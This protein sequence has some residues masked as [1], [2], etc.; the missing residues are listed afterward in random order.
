MKSSPASITAGD[1]F[2]AAHRAGHHALLLIIKV[3]YDKFL[4][5]PA[6]YQVHI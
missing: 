6:D 2:N 5:G 3:Y 1:D 4:T